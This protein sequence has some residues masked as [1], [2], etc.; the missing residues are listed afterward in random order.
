MI[1]DS[2]ARKMYKE[3]KSKIG[4]NK[5]LRVAGLRRHG[6]DEGDVLRCT[7]SSNIKLGI[8]LT[9]KKYIEDNN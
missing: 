3:L 1:T 9:Y 5:T 6:M 8:E 4:K 2:Q 7:L